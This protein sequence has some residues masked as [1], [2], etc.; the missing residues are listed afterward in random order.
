M[1]EDLKLGIGLD[2][3]EALQSLVNLTKESTRFTRKASK[4]FSKLNIAVGSFV[5]SLGS[6]AVSAGLGQISR[7]FSQATT[8]A[9]G[10]SRGIGEINTLLPKNAKLTAQAEDAILGFSSRFGQDITD[11]TRAFYQIISAGITDTGQALNFLEKSSQAATAGLATVAEAADLVTSQFNVFGKTGETADSIFD[12]VFETVRLGKT[13]FGELAQNLGQVSPFAA[14]AGASFDEVAGTLAF[15][16]KNGIKTD[17]AVRGLRQVFA[18]LVKPSA[19]AKEIAKSLGIEFS[20]TAIKG[21]K[22][23]SFLKDLADKTKGNE[24]ALSQLFANVR[25]LNPILAIVRGDFADFEKIL[26]QVKGATGSTAEAFANIEKTFDF[27]LTR[28]GKNFQVL[29]VQIF[30]NFVPGLTTAIVKFNEFL[31]TVDVRDIT[32]GITAFGRVINDFVIRPIESAI[33]IFGNFDSVA[34]FVFASIAAE[35]LKMATSISDSIFGFFKVKN[36]FKSVMTAASGVFEKVAVEAS[37]NVTKAFDN[38]NISEGLNKFFDKAD[39]TASIRAT[40]LGATIKDGLTG[41]F[42]GGQEEQDSGGQEFLIA[43]QIDQEFTDTLVSLNGFQMAFVDGI[44]TATNQGKEKFIAFAEDVKKFSKQI[45]TTLMS[46]LASGA[47][48]AFAAFGAALAKGENALDAFLKAFLESMGKMAIQVGT[49]FILKGLAY[50]FAGLPNGGAL[51]AAGAALAA[52]GGVMG[53]VFGGG[54]DSGGGGVAGGNLAPDL[55]DDLAEAPEVQEEKSTAVNV[56]VEG[57]VVDQ[58]EFFVRMADGIRDAVQQ[59]GA[60]LEVRQG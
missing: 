24:A 9:R 28:L 51:I 39:E 13:T 29:G 34:T 21:G 35:A 4:G 48:N 54:G 10:F 57:N 19:E 17:I 37:E 25:A 52:F 12:K 47:G 16:T 43:A 1:A 41:N 18:T 44:N 32:S 26:L 58:D 55:S 59:D 50:S 2:E 27:Q 23:A 15:L 56:T 20:S 49:M 6:R 3:R 33:A 40:Q 38:N 8:L 5:G 53:A 11:Q 36:P 60:I 45:K 30:K 7:G 31:S 42:G 14:A 46:G 22:F